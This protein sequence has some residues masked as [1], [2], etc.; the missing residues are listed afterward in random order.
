MA[1]CWLTRCSHWGL[2]FLLERVEKGAGVASI[3]H[4]PLTSNG[5]FFNSYMSFEHHA[6]TFSSPPILCINVYRPPHHS[7]SF[8][9]EFSE[10]L[11][12]IHTSYTHPGP[13]HN[14]W[15]FHWFCP[16]YTT[17]YFLTSPVLTKRRPRWTLR[18]RYITSEVAANFMGILQSTPAEILPAP[19]NFIVDN[20]NSR[21]KSTSRFIC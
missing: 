10:L 15:P 20:F 1:W 11:S 16:L 2:V 17:V 3:T 14:P 18:R 9:S 7:T 19:C 5:V 6:F 21:L 12:I 8:I 13:G 4:K